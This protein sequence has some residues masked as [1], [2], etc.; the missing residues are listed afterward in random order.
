MR[1]FMKASHLVQIFFEENGGKA[2]KL[3]F[4]ILFENK[5]MFTVSLLTDST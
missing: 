1:K 3:Y 4:W 5:I 2:P